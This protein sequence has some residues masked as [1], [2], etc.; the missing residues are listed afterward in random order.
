MGALLIIPGLVMG[1]YVGY[2]YI[3]YDIKY[4]LKGISP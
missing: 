3:F 2:W 1:A 4:Y